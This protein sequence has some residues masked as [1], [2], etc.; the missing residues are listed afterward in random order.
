MR[1]RA[2]LIALLELVVPMFPGEQGEP[3]ATCLALHQ[4][5][6]SFLDVGTTYEEL[7]NTKTKLKNA[8]RDVRMARS[9]TL[10]MRISEAW[11]KSSE[12]HDEFV[13]YLEYLS[14]TGLWT[15]V[16]LDQIYT[17]TINKAKGAYSV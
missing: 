10:G 13:S 9:H 16:E 1:E 4:K 11:V 15:E 2:G 17:S 6:Q 5:L 7:T 3:F 8:W 14:T 12:S